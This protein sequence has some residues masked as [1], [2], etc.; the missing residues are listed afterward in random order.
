MRPS[1]RCITRSAIPAIATLWVMTTVVVPSSRVDPGDD[2][3]HD[4]A[5]RIVERAGRLVAEQHVGTLGDRAGDRDA[6]LLAAGELRREVVEALRQADAIERLLR[7]HRRHRDVGDERDVLAHGEARDQ[8]VELEDEAD[9]LA[10]VARQFG[11]ARGGE[12]VVPPERFTRRRRV[13]SAQDV[14]QRRLAAARGAEEDDELALADLEIESGERMHFDLAHPVGLGQAPG[15]EDR[16][17]PVGVDR[18]HPCPAY[19]AAHPIGSHIPGAGER[20]L[21]QIK[22][23]L[24]FDRVSR[25][26]C[27][28]CARFD[29]AP[30]SDQVTFAGSQRPSGR[31]GDNHGLPPKA[32]HSHVQAVP[33]ALGV[34]RARRA[35]GRHRRVRLRFRRRPAGRRDRGEA[36]D[37]AADGRGQRSRPDAGNRRDRRDDHRSRRQ[38]P[39]R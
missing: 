38:D 17:A 32:A 4:L 8:V 18:I 29:R 21:P 1:A 12:V 16:G 39:C 36:H 33:A 23:R 10:P 15:D 25:R 6:L 13:E 5:G 34:C 28:S 3:E 24:A 20:P 27:A 14:E 2:L 19:V 26:Q 11:L 9:V 31:T 37:P 7:R 30:G 22:K 35:G